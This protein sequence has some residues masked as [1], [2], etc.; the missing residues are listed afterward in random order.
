M[1]NNFIDI[2]LLDFEVDIILQAL[3]D[4]NYGI[5]SKYNFRKYIETREEGTERIIARNIYDQIL[6]VKAE[7]NKKQRNLHHKENIKNNSKLI[8]NQ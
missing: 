2:R 5:N 6:Y 1:N 3:L 8:D 7:Y 4:Y